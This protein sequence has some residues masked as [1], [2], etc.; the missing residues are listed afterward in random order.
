MNEAAASCLVNFVVF[1]IYA[2]PTYFLF[3]ANKKKQDFQKR[4]Y[5]NGYFE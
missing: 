1:V 3:R 5:L 2:V 4:K